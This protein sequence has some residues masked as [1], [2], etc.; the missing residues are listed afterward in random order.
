[1]RKLLAMVAVL[2]VAVSCENVSVESVNRNEE[3]SNVLHAYICD[4]SRA[5]F[6]EK[7]NTRWNEGD[8]I[9]VFEGKTRN[10]KYLFLGKD[11]DN[12][13]DFE[14]KTTSLGSAN[15]LDNPCYYAVYPYNQSISIHENGT[16]KIYWPEV[17]NYLA[18]SAGI[19][20]NIMVA[21]TADMEDTDL[22]FRNVGSYLRVRL[23]GAGQV[24][25]SLVLEG[26]GGELLNG[27][28][29][30][31]ASY[32]AAPQG[33]MLS[34]GTTLTLDCG[35]G[36]AIGATEAEATEFW[37]VVPEVVMQGGL[38][39]TVNGDSGS[40]QYVVN[41][42]VTFA[43]NKYNTMT[44][45]LTELNGE[46]VYGNDIIEANL[47]STRT[48]LDANGTTTYWKEG[49]KMGVFTSEGS[50]NLLFTSPTAS[51]AWTGIFRGS[52]NGETPK[53]AY[54]P[55]SATA[56][57]DRTAIK[58]NLAAEQ[59]VTNFGAYDIKR[60]TN[61]DY[62][63]VNASL[64]FTGV[65]S[66]IYIYVNAVDTQL[67]DC[68]L[69]SVTVTASPLNEGDPAPA[70]SGDFVMNLEAG[71]TAFGG[72]TQ[73]YA[74]LVWPTPH[75]FSESAAVANLMVNPAGFKAGTK[76]SIVIDTVEGK[77]ATINASAPKDFAPNTRYK[78]TINL[79][80]I[81]SAVYTDVNEGS[82]E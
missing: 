42:K 53:Y 41:S 7:I 2:L 72:T 4:E 17:Q 31:V 24:V 35:E 59:D 13:G 46:V 23:Y 29:E 51:E 28:A 78:L 48:Y 70:V 25:K 30:V 79:A 20:A 63:G 55:Y 26:N 65:L 43:R 76:Y 10:K 68:Q 14:N 73:N 12:S 71:T 32:D 6:D 69:K 64:D 54:Y 5:Y 36:V 44:R 57:N 82:A 27:E 39:L 49:D 40:Q 34:G 58:L 19:G 38:T 11:G 15:R 8:L 81:A 22:Y 62:S 37:F 75:L 21:A 66:M 60:S 33:T 18:K 1:M 50:A 77:R 9:T 3:S 47:S 74:S 16:L 52:L 61:A 45:E 56:G 80:N 67:Y